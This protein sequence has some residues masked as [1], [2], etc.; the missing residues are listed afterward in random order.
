MGISNYFTEMSLNQ[1]LKDELKGSIGIETQVVCTK[2]LKAEH[3]Q[4]I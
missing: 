2:R 1:S 3:I 4:E